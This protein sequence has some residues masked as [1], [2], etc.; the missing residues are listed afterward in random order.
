MNATG[1]QPCKMRHI[2]HQIGAH[3]VGNGAKPG[4]ID[5][6]RIGRAPGHDDFRLV[7]L[8]E[9]LDFFEVYPMIVLSYAVLNGVHPLAR[10][11]RLGPVSQVS[12][13]GQGH[14]EDRIAR[15]AERDIHTQIGL[16]A[17]MRLHVYISAIEKLFCPFAGQ[18]LSDI[19]ILAAAVI[20]A[21]GISFRIFVGHHGPG[22]F[23]DRLRDDIL[24]GDQFDL[25]LQPAKFAPDRLVELRIPIRE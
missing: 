2:D 10:K 11:V 25:P 3:L 20:A 16:R 13:R 23:E 18:F 24:R 7:L 17:R 19:D 4:E 14:P 9:P 8:C 15:L 1:N 22:R 6:P 5:N 12:A 21:S